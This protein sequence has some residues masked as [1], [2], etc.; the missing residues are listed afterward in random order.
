MLLD[1]HLGVVMTNDKDPDKE[2]G[3]EAR[4]DSLV[5]DEIYP[6]IVK[7]LFPANMAKAPDVGQIVEI[8]VVADEEDE[9]GE[10][11]YGVTEFTDFIYYRG[12]TFDSNKGKIPNELKQNYPKRAGMFFDNGTLI[13]VDETKNQETILIRL[14]S[15]GPLIQL[16]TVG[17]KILIGSTSA[18]E[19]IIKGTT[20]GSNFSTFM[21]TWITAMSALTGASDPIVSTYATTMGTALSTLAG[22]V[23][24]WKSIKRFID[25]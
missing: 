10:S 2:F 15:N 21:T 16:Q 17:D 11:S 25:G 1:T 7:P 6:I 18:A 14:K 3:I 8:I 4:I 19:A 5:P 12:R 22:Q 20:F 23:N 9:F 13:I 24:A